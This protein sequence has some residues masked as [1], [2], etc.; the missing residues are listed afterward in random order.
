MKDTLRL[1]SFHLHMLPYAVTIA[2]PFGSS[3]G[4]RR[5]IQPCKQER[6]WAATGMTPY[7]WQRKTCKPGS[8]PCLT[9]PYAISDAKYPHGWRSGTWTRSTQTC[10]PDIFTARPSP[11][12]QSGVKNLRISKQV[13]NYIIFYAVLSRFRRLRFLYEA[14]VQRYIATTLSLEF[15]TPLSTSS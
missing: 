14:P 8:N 4:L 15:T 1:L 11:P 10:C 12:P 13:G 2:Y 6:V 7:C 9:T 5:C 3:R